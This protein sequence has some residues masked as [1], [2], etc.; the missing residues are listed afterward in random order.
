MSSCLGCAHLGASH[1]QPWAGMSWARHQAGSAALPK[2]PLPPRVLSERAEMCSL[3]SLRAGCG[4]PFQFIQAKLN[5]SFQITNA[6]AP[7]EAARLHLPLC[8]HSCR[9]RPALRELRLAQAIFWKAARRRRFIY[10]L[11]SSSFLLCLQYGA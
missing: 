2:Q 10:I 3:I 8:T 1:A 6:A 11:P 5:R 9:G 4:L 7:R